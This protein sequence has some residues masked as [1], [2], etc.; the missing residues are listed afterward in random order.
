MAQGEES[1]ALLAGE[2]AAPLPR[3][4]GA[5]NGRGLWTL[6]RRGVVR[7]FRYGWET[8]G[9]ALVSS[10]LFLTVFVLAAGAGREVA[11]G[12]EFSAFIV[13]GIVIFS[14]CHTAFEGAAV[15]VPSRSREAI[16]V[17]QGPAFQGLEGDFGACA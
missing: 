12:L 9:G 11:P 15:A 6:Y 4:F 3:C 1:L 10:L 16:E 13:P 14:L 17:A 2:A 7:H 8:L 5:I